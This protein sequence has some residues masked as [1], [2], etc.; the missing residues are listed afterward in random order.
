LIKHLSSSYEFEI[1]DM[2]D[3]LQEAATRIK[4]L[5]A[6]NWRLTAKNRRNARCY[7]R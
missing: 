6:S 1:A 3:L 2:R 4:E 7:G 5:D